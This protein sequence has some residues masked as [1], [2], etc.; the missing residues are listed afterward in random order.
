MKK[1]WEIFDTRIRSAN[2]ARR[3]LP[4]IKVGDDEK[5]QLIGAL[6]QNEAQNTDRVIYIHIPFC[7]NICPFC[8]YSKQKT[9][10]NELISNYF[11]VLIQQIKAL[12][13]SIWV[14][15][16][17]FK[18]VYFGGGTPTSVSVHHLEAILNE[19][20]KSIPLSTDCEITVESTITDLTPEKLSVLK[21]AGVNRM[22]LG[23]QSFDKQTRKSLGRIAGSDE[24]S[25]TI[26]SIH[27]DGISNI[28]IDLL[29]NLKDQ[30]FATWKHDLA[31]ISKNLITGCSVYSLISTH[32][33]AQTSEVR[34]PELLEKEY[35]FFTEADE[36]LPEIDG[37]ERFTTV[38][39]GHRKNGKATYVSAHGQNADLLAFGSGA[40]GRI[41]NINYIQTGNVEE[42][43]NAQGDFMNDPIL[44]LSIDEKYLKL[45]A[46]F[47][48]SEALSLKLTDYQDLESYFEDIIAQLINDG[49][50]IIRDKALVLT[51]NGRFW[52]A[53]ISALFT[54]RIREILIN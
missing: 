38:Q 21:N 31:A 46:I 24:I 22:S 33:R 7:S 10:D 4:F 45:R 49:L 8:I 51:P 47:S 16:A 34:E 29:Y 53:N 52:A 23:V 18:A 12:S 1:P 48:L 27:K 41:N 17:P 15:S 6:F 9:N 42:Y 19:L 43:I 20:E 11:T 32:T 39:Y 28:C 30:N 13:S 35:K 37:W 25:E 3:S 2:M 54:Q 36:R 50:V 40:G 5:Q 14:Q 26:E 44:F